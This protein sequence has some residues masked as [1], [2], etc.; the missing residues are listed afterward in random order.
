MQHVVFYE[1]R[2][3]AR[4]HDIWAL[5]GGYKY[6]SILGDL[7]RRARLTVLM[8]QLPP[9]GDPLR[10]ELTR[11]YG[12]T[13]EQLD[14]EEPM[15]PAF[16]GQLASDLTASLRRLRP[17]IVSNLNG[18][19]I[20]FCYAMA[21]A[22]H[23]L[24]IDY[25]MRLGGNDL[26]ARGERFEKLDRPFWGTRHYFDRLVQERVAMHVSS[27]IIVM[28]ERE[29]LRLVSMT[30]DP[31]KVALCFRGVDQ[32]HFRPPAGWRPRR[33]RRFL[34][35][36]RRSLEKGYD[37]LD[38]AMDILAGRNPALT[39][40]FAGTFEPGEAG[41]RRYAGFIDYAR[42]PELY[43]QHD[44]L[45]VC[46]RSEG[47]PQVIMEAMSC[48]L[49]CILTRSIFQRDFEDGA[50]ALMTAARPPDVAAAMQR[51]ADDEDLYR[52]L[53]RNSL[54]LAKEQFS[55]DHNRAR[56]HRILMGA[57]GGDG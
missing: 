11:D 52:R 42:L 26:E 9:Q 5:R 47:F 35:V 38:D 25:V 31:G 19:G 34:F 20:G 3:V 50:T 21:K 23:R 27:R 54:A 33:C 12:I 1:P 55:E 45:V 49:P 17:D 10:L 53:A 6:K 56:Y 43:A 48:G 22:A 40:T 44:A 4:H 18:R 57:G 8:S 29:R 41:N 14:S 15:A 30:V 24:G 16:A 28:S 37:I 13:F 36:G 2:Y 7:G 32:Q 39:A 51:L 46:S